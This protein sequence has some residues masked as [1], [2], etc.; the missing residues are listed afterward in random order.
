MRTQLLLLCLVLGGFLLSF[1]CL[2]EQA[3]PAAPAYNSSPTLPPVNPIDNTPK[4]NLTNYTAP[5]TMTSPFELSFINLSLSDATL[6]RTSNR[7]VLFDAGSADMAP[8]LVA[9]LRAKNI[10]HIDLL[11]LSSDDPAFVGGAPEVLRNFPV[12]EVW[13]NGGNYS[14]YLWSTIKSSIGT[15]PVRSVSYGDNRTWGE[16]EV[17]VVNPQLT[18]L[19]G[20]GDSTVLKVSYGSFCSLLF[21]NSVAAGASSI[22]AGTVTGGVDSRIVSG[23]IPV[24]CPVLRV[25]HHGS[26]NSAS[27]QLLNQVN[28]TDAIISV[29]PDPPQNLYPS[30]TLLRR[31]VLNNATVWT[32]DR[33]GTVT[34]TSDGTTYHIASE[35]SRDT[36][37]GHFLENVVYSGA[38]YW[39]P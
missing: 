16:M 15:V 6:I 32:T 25:S 26:A 31:L 12:T 20:D 9:Y 39:A 24:T 4:P 28:P 8:T 37:F 36:A 35:V 33:L 34:V 7:T 14:D 11:V 27:F 5:S 21:S 18:R 29:G 23:P 13:T 3:S 19:S 10:D 30:P 17:M 38:D 1:G 22:D 2:G